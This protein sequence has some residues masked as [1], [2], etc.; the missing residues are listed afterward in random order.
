MFNLNLLIGE[1]H[2]L[3]KSK[4]KSTLSFFSRNYQTHE[5]SSAD[6]AIIIHVEKGFGVPFVNYNVVVSNDAN[7]ISFTRADYQI[8]VD[9]SYSTARINVYDELALKH[10]LLNLYSSFILHHNWGLLIHSSCVIDKGIAHIFAGASGAGKSTAAKLSYPRDLLSDE[11][12]I[13]KVSS[14]GITVF[15]SPFRSEINM[16]KPMDPVPLSSIQFLHQSLYTKRTTLKKSNGLIKL[17]DKVFY[18]PYKDDEYRSIMH[19]LQTVVMQVP[20]YD[21]M[22]KKD[23]TFWELIS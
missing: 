19:L 13:I 6:P 16:K 23:P 11:A 10:A 7:S 1:H 15:P 5:E 12:T 8:V 17:I 18:W 21:L 4:S 2:F 14:D 22:F 3:I 9:P 20:T